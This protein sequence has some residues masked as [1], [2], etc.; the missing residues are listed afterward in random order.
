MKSR[1][2]LF[3]IRDGFGTG[4]RA[5]INSLFI[6][7]IFENASQARFISHSEVE[8]DKG[9]T[10]SVAIQAKQHRDRGSL[11]APPSH[12]TQHTGPYC[13]VRLIKAEQIQENN[14]DLVQLSIPDSPVPEANRHLHSHRK[15]STGD[16]YII[17]CVV[18]LGFHRAGSAC[19]AFGHTR[20]NGIFSHCCN[21][22]IRRLP[23]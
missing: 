13:A 16:D 3:S 10:P 8:S 4:F 11:A 20:H 22:F 1:F 2:Y 23:Y 6:P 17:T 21:D 14:L 15:L 12:T 7:S 18:P 9:A 5:L 19:R